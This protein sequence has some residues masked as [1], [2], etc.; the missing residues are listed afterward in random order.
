[1]SSNSRSYDALVVGGGHNGLVTA[2]LLRKRGFRVVVLER[3]HVVGGAAVTEQPWGPDYKMTSLSYVMS[4]LS[5][6]VLKELQLERF[7]YKIYPQHGYFAPY[8]DGRFLMMPSDAARR[9]EQIAKFSKKDA[10]AME[11]WD[12]WLG[13]LS[14]FFGPILS[15]IPPAFGSKSM[16][17]LLDQAQFAWRMRGL[18]PGHVADVTRLMTMSVADLLE[19]NFESPRS[20]VCWR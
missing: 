10:Q 6:A 8:S 3:R 19:E 17:D 13:A 9:H 18:N 4:H 11:R 12:A 1:M 7:G 20:K 2:G 15:S 5:P 16:G 14:T